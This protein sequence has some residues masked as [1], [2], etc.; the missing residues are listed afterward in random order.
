[1]MDRNK[2]IMDRIL[3]FRNNMLFNP[4]T[5]IG[6]QYRPYLFRLMDVIILLV[7]K[8]GGTYRIPPLQNYLDEY[9][10]GES[11]EVGLFHDKIIKQELGKLGWQ[12]E[13]EELIL[14]FNAEEEEIGLVTLERWDEVVEESIA[15]FDPIESVMIKRLLDSICYTDTAGEEDVV[16]LEETIRSGSCIILKGPAIRPEI[17]NGGDEVMEQALTR[18]AKMECIHDYIHSLIYQYNEE[19]TYLVFITYGY[20]LTDEYDYEVNNELFYFPG[21]ILCAQSLQDIMS[22]KEEG[23]S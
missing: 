7:L 16:C 12:Y 11:N 1:M 10:D 8:V 15:G 9:D 20:Y 18:I 17:R 14:P 5:D 13:M 6:Y 3:S 19:E 22:G 23:S 21:V 2:E 4:Y